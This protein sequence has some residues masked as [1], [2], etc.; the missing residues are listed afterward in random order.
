LTSLGGSL[1][2]GRALRTNQRSM[3]EMRATIR[4]SRSATACPSPTRR[5]WRSYP[6][7]PELIPMPMRQAMC[8]SQAGVVDGTQTRLNSSTWEGGKLRFAGLDRL[9]QEDSLRV[10][11]EEGGPLMRIASHAP[12]D[13]SRQSNGAR[14]GSRAW[15]REHRRLPGHSECSSGRYRVA[16]GAP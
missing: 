8:F 4:S 6:K 13:F 10:T 15:L 1:S 7:S 11:W 2:L 12:V 3:W 14:L 16:R 9:A 5:K